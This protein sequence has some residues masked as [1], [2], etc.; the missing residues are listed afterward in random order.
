VTTLQRAV[1]VAEMQSRELARR[2]VA[3]GLFALLPAA[4]YLS[5]PADQDY[6]LLAGAIGVSWAV[7]A[8]GLF[9][10]LGWRRVDPRLALL[11]A[12]PIEGMLGRLLVGSALALVLVAVYAPLML[13]RSST[14]I[15]DEWAFVGALLTVAAVSVPMGL[16][17]GALL[18][19]ELEG[20]LVLIGVVGV[21]SSI[22]PDTTLAAM[23]P[24]Y[25]PFELLALSIGM[26]DP[27]AAVGLAHAAFST[28]AM[29][30]IAH[31][32]WRRRQRITTGQER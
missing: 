11:G 26:G 27:S 19:R 22:P 20:T 17:I 23:L 4:F 30:A 31:L 15:V 2:H 7:A 1:V 29:A 10:T 32:L 8:A 28:V 18:P 3:M 24:L 12:R 5:I 16:L 25:G 9:G 13:V 6:G 14:L 21:E